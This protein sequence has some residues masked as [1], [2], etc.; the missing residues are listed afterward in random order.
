MN[1][2][3]GKKSHNGRTMAKKYNF[4]I[5]YQFKKIPAKYV[6]V[7][8]DPQTRKLDKDGIAELTHSPKNCEIF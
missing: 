4:S 5:I 8:C 7:W 6:K 3:H 2:K 1:I